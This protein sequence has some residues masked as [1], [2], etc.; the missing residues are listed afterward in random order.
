[1]PLALAL[2]FLLSLLV[3][4]VPAMAQDTPADEPP[5]SGDEPMDEG[6]AEEDEESGEDEVDGPST[7]QMAAQM[8]Q[9]VRMLDAQLARIDDPEQLRQMLAMMEAQVAQ[10]GDVPPEARMGMQM[11]RAK[12]QARIDE[13]TGGGSQQADAAEEAVADVPA[14]PQQQEALEAWMHTVL[15]GRPDLARAAAEILLA[16]ALSDKAMADMVDR[17]GLGERFDR[18]VTASRSMEG[19]SRLSEMLS[20]KLEAG[21]LAMAR[22]PVRIRQSVSQLTGTLRQQALAMQRLEAAGAFA[23]PPLLKVI[24]DG[25][26]SQMGVMAERALLQI[27]RPAAVPLCEALL[28]LPASRQLVVCRLLGSIGSRVAAPWLASLAAQPGVTSDVRS[29]AMDAMSR[30]GVGSVEPAPLWTS[31][32][33]SYLVGGDGLLPYPSEAMQV[34]WNF[35]SD[36]GL[37]PRELPSD[38]YLDTMAQRCA[39]QAMRLDDQDSL[40]LSVYLAAGLR[41]APEGTG[42]E[43]GELSPQAMVMAAGPGVAQQ[44]LSLAQEIRDPGLQLSAIRVLARTASAASLTASGESGPMNRALESSNRLVRL[45]AALTWASAMPSSSFGRCDSVVPILAAAMRAGGRPS[46]AVLAEQDEDRRVIEGWLQQA[47]FV[48]LG[49]DRSM[50]G[51]RS[52]LTGRGMP[53]MVVVAG[54]AATVNVQSQR[55]RSESVTGGSLLLLAVPE[56]ERGLL[57]RSLREDRG[58]NMWMLG[59]GSDTFLGAVQVL[60]ERAGGGASTPEMSTTMAMAAASALARIGASGGGVFRMQ[61]AELDLIDALREQSGDLRMEVAEVLAWVPT[62]AAQRALLGKALEPAD[63]DEQAGLLRAAAASARRFGDKADPGQVE[64]L[65]EIMTGGA[66]QVSDAAAACYGALNLGPRETI[67]MIVR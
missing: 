46:A 65:R 20:A 8:A 34:L 32:A 66:G 50:E 16:P 19:V 33:R 55:V 39:T 40:A 58:V 18:A 51:L 12:V 38:P 63:A 59:D 47:G 15:I 60:Q 56:T 22:D 44:V 54:S 25:Q 67:R 48:L 21:R 3:C 13:L 6:D 43:D 31:L 17:A 52:A 49:G 37:M 36:H 41:L 24:M 27:G 2:A 28:Q 10:M 1:M 64:R 23:V 30:I 4:P 42:S 29:A 5:V 57:D 62:E 7:T 45:E 53:D 26:D 11:L 61:D 35:D 9:A 14:T